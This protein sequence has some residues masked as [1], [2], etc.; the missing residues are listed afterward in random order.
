MGITITAVDPPLVRPGGPAHRVLARLLGA[1]LD[2]QLAAGRPPESTPLLAARAQLIVALPWRTKMAANWQRLLARAAGRQALASRS[3]PVGAVP[4]CAREISAAAPAVEELVTRLEA[5]LPV[6]ARGV[7]MA[8]TLLTDATGPV[9]SRHS[10]VPLEV[11]LQAAIAQLD[12][13]LP[14]MAGR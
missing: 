14:L 4:V 11:A 13:A 12:P 1:S 5:P 9:Y 3:A 2:R 6:P 8:T 7:A 10:P